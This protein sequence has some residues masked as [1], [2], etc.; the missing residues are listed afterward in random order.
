[1]EDQDL[2]F[3]RS[4]MEDSL[5]Q[6]MKDLALIIQESKKASIAQ[7]RHDILDR[8]RQ[9]SEPAPDSIPKPVR[10]GLRLPDGSRLNRLFS[11]NS[12]FEVS[13]AHPVVFTCRLF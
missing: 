1:M 9:L 12:K 6:D 4:L 10:V 5:K 13:L 2:A 7:A 11:P 3:H 8:Y